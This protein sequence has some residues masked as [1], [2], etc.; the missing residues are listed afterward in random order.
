MSKYKKQG[1]VVFKCD[2]HLVWVPKYRYRILVGDV[3]KQAD[4]DIRQ[5]SEFLDVR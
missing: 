4:R 2:Y 5:L 1:H 3:A